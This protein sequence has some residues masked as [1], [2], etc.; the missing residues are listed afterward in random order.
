MKELF[1]TFIESYGLGITML[2][3]G[4]LVVAFMIE[5]S[6][7]NGFN[8]IESKVSDGKVKSILPIIRFFSIL[9]GS[10]VF[11]GAATD[12]VIEQWGLP[13]NGFVKFIWWSISYLSQ[14]VFSLCGIKGMLYL[15]DWGRA[16]NAIREKERAELKALAEA[17]KPHL[18]PV[19]GT[20]D[21]FVTDDGQY[22]N[23]KGRPV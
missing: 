1:N 17:N 7:K 15:I 5:I 8:W 9:V 13:A 3:V 21:L 2:V 23:S 18:T 4:G 6:I 12:G 14:Y 22:V 19:A 20:K 10:V 16:R 11:T